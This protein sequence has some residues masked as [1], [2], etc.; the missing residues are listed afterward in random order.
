MKKVKSTEPKREFPTWLLDREKIKKCEVDLQEKLEQT[1]D[2]EALKD[3]EAAALFL[4]QS[5][6][7]MR[8]RV[9]AA[10]GKAIEKLDAEKAAG[11]KA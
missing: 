2:I 8:I 7:G 4:A 1:N 5:F 10:I 11:G 6:A 3:I 9:W